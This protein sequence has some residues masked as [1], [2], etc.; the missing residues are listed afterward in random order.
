MLVDYVKMGIS[1]VFVMVGQIDNDE[2]DNNGTDVSMSICSSL[3][4]RAKVGNVKD[5]NSLALRI[6]SSSSSSWRKGWLR[7]SRAL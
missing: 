2:D 6:T 3:A 1:L 7:A 5:Q 4:G